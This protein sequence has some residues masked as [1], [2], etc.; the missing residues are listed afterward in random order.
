MTPA[1]WIETLVSLAVQASVVIA[2]AFAVDRRSSGP[3]AAGRAW[4]ACF[5]GLFVLTAAALTLPRF[6]PFV[7]WDGVPVE[8][9]WAAAETELAVGGAL[10]GLW[11]AGVGAALLS[12]SVRAVRIHCLIG[13]SRPLE[14][15]SLAPFLKAAGLPR[16]GSSAPTVLVSDEID[17]PFCRQFHRQV[18]VLPIF[19]LDAAPTEL[20]PVL[21]HECEHLR[22]QHPLQLFLQHG[23]RALFWFHPAAW[24]AGERASLAREYVCDDAAV[25][26]PAETAVYLRALLNIAE[27]A[28]RRTPIGTLTFGGGA[29][30]IVSRVRRLTAKAGGAAASGRRRLGQS[31]ATATVAAACLIASQICVPL[32]ALASSRASYSPWPTWT[33][34]TLHAF[35]VPVRDSEPFDAHLPLH[36]VR[37]KLQGGNR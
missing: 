28:E 34:R 27:R 36:E 20:A 12:W 15:E 22:Q 16:D 33:A 3:R 29:E 10:A 23:V 8:V 9:R 21:R 25:P 14:H 24:R 31:A 26:N 37:E 11:L 35:D 4:T 32:D 13:R 18:I 1:Q 5:A 7:P 6:R 30:A 17:G 19:L 2:A